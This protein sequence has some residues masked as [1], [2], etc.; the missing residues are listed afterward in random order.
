MVLKI[1]LGFN[2]GIATAENLM[3]HI[4]AITNNDPI[5]VR[6]KNMKDEHRKFLSPM[7]EELKS[8]SNY[9]ARK[10]AVEEYNKVQKISCLV[11]LIQ[12]CFTNS[13]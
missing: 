13:H 8:S 12:T 4:A 1:S 10:Q 2:E 9:N 3:E 6:L 5:E 11:I 7:V